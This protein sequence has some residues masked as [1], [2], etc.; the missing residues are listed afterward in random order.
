MVYFPCLYPQPWCTHS[1]TH[2]STRYPHIH[3][4]PHYPYDHPHIQPPIQPTTQPLVHLHTPETFFQVLRDSFIGETA[5]TVMIANISPTA[6][7]V[8]HTLNTLRYADRV[9]GEQSGFPS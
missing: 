4:L 7:C 2:Q 3:R 5:R 8:E 9:K 6:S 1:P